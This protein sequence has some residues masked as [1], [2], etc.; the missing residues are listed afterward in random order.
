M[1]INT[2][3]ILR[4]FAAISVLITHVFQK[5]NFKP[6]GDYFLS[7]QY[8]VDIFFVLSGF[9]IYLTTKEQTDPWKYLKKEY[10]EFILY[11]YLHYCFIS[12][13]KS[14]SKILA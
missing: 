11:I 5:S 14:V 8:G 1:Q 13:I 3:Q 12:Y 4:A 10:S 9:L 2:L 7:G 6:F